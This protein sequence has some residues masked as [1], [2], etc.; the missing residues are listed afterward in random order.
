MEQV[1]KNEETDDLPDAENAGSNVSRRGLIA[2]GAAI[3]PA[4]AD[5]GAT[6]RPVAA[7]EGGVRAK[8]NHPAIFVS[9]L[10]RS[11]A[12]YQQAF[13]FELVV[14][15]TSGERVSGGKTSAMNLPGAHL[16]DRDGDRI[17]FW[18]LSGTSGSEH[19]QNPINHF[20][21]EVD[22]VG[23]AYETALAA[24]ATSDLEPGTVTSGELRVDTAF[25]RG[26]D[27]ERIE[28]LRFY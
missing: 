15:W 23:M 25:V 14:R 21:L 17:E 20:G 24:G 4:V 12:F 16:V 11:I 6:S 9:D 19:T 22:D 27:D 10:D 28:L 18:Q 1:M 2:T 5:I 3:G 8:L 7:Q 26:P 13:G